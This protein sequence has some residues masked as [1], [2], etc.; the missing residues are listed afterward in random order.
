MKRI[1]S[2]KIKIIIPVLFILIVVFL[3]SSLVII[4]REYKIAKDSLIN[5]A[6]SYSSLSSATLVNNYI[7]YYESGF[8]QF[9][10]IVDELMELNKN[11]VYYIQILD[12]NGK[13]L[14]DTNEMID[15][16]K[17]DE[18]TSGERYLPEDL[19]GKADDPQKTTMVFEEKQYV[20]IIQPY[21][22][23]WGRH[24]YT[25]RYLFSLSSLEETRNEMIFTAFTY[26][27]IF[28]LISFLFIY[29]LISGYITSPIGRL[30][31][32]V[33]L[34]SE[35]KLGLTVKVTTQDE[36]GELASAFNKMSKD[37]EKSQ[38]SLQ[39][40]LKQKDEFINQLGHDLKTPL[41]PLTSLIPILEEKEKDSIKKEWFE[42]LHRNVDYMKSLVLK[43]LELAKLNSP[44]T[45]FSIEEL[46]LKDEVKK[47]I[48]NK[49]TLFETKNIKVQNK[50][51][52]K[53]IVKADRLRLEEL[54]TNI[55]ENSVKYTK[56]KGRITINLENKN[57]FAK[58][59][60]KD[61][62]IGIS[63]EQ[64]KYIFDEFYKAD[65]SRHDFG[66]SGLGM[67]ICKRIIEKH[68]GKIWIE[69][70]GIGKGTTVFFT[71]PLVKN[72][73]G[74]NNTKK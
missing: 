52:N 45:K 32:G 21:T 38:E 44:R 56:E 12:V 47:I 4:D 6:E 64:I 36:M 1:L 73:K 3:A 54:F 22:D 13:I 27:V 62:G 65:E 25:V 23:E 30:I 39:N 50:I 61:N 8:Y 69:S 26:S 60:I 24:E 34:M 33:R 17:Y 35:G 31:K 16:T 19:I 74:F 70:P 66:S 29:F 28:I 58:I 2:L 18:T 20:D 72:I 55:F 41:M 43:T 10:G 59:S 40:L 42:V 9:I 15:K 51:S 11:V 53:Y 14:F 49:K 63:K 37:L 48:E 5:S 68:D 57:G 67:S 46:E 7:L 71:L